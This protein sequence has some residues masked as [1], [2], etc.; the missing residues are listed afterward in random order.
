MKRFFHNPYRPLEK[1]LGYTFRNKELLATALLHR[2]FRYESAGIRHDNQ[3][4]EFLGDA[5]LGIVAGDYL[6]RAYPE[7][8]EGPLTLL[9]S[10]LTSGK[11]LA[12]IGG[13]INLG[14]AIKLGK[15]EQASGGRQRDSNI[16]D[17][18]EA[19]LGAAYL[20]G[21]L[22]AV[23]KIFQTLF[24]PLIAIHPEDG[25]QDNPKGQLQV[26]AQREW[27]TNPAYHLV[28]R[29]GPP[30]ASM[31]TVEAVIRGKVSGIGKGASKRE[32]E[33]SAARQALQALPPTGNE[34]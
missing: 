8:E 25:W 30:H 14:A 21:D 31:F 29:V 7:L 13:A 9:R 28:S 10:R 27:K 22:K 17:A 19:I 11:A 1:L 24:V 18:L 15:G 26:I 20:D 5:A 32:A 12:R 4:L 2:S 6:F 33:Q 16:T 23:R 3:R 34:T